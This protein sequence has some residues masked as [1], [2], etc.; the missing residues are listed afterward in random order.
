MLW[1]A[2]TIYILLIISS[3]ILEKLVKRKFNLAKELKY[4]KRFSKNQTL[5][6]NLMLI[7]FF[8]GLF[9]SNITV[10]EK[11]IYRP[12]NPIPIYLWFSLYLFVLLGFRGYMA[13]RVDK[14]S[15]EYYIHFVF[16]VWFP[17]IFIIAYHTTK[18]F[19]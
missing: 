13:K 3:F 12:F 1:V 17:I 14:D 11:N 7:I 6:E 9:M 2:I 18:I 19:L 4:N 5:I 8:I 16:A 15:R 10:L